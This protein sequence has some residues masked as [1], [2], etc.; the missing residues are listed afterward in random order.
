MGKRYYLQTSPEYY[1]KR[2]LA[3]SGPIFQMTHVFRGEERGR[4]HQPEFTLLEWY[5]LQPTLSL[6]LEEVDLFYK[7][8]WAALP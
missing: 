4:W 3:G 6:L 5:Q 1:M 2:L 7:Q 8:C